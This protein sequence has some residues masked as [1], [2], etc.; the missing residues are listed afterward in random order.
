MKRRVFIVMLMVV[1]A[2]TVLTGCG[3]T[4]TNN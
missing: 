2:L 4:A 1:F 3:D